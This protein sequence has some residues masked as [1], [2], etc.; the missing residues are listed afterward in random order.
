[1]LTCIAKITVRIAL[2]NT[3]R[4]IK[5]NQ[6]ENYQGVGRHIQFTR[7]TLNKE[8]VYDVVNT[9]LWCEGSI[10]TISVSIISPN[11]IVLFLWYLLFT[12]YAN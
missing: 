4:R 7:T 1:M 6:G 12:S 8:T 9:R 10:H 3:L 2:Q 11:I 5:S